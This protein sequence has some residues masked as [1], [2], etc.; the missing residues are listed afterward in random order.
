M[1]FAWQQ[2]KNGPIEANTLKHPI[3]KKLKLQIENGIFF[4]LSYLMV[5]LK[6][7]F[8]LLR[9]F[10]SLFLLTFLHPKKFKIVDFRAWD[11]AGIG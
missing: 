6:E 10:K 2:F 11:S 8:I 7:H 3:K 5:A 1:C 9:I 4:C